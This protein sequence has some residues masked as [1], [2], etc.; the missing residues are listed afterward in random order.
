MDYINR[1][2]GFCDAESPIPGLWRI[3]PQT[4]AQA[5]FPEMHLSSWL[6][7]Q[8]GEVPIYAIEPAGARPV[9]ACYEWLAR[10]IQPDTIILVDGGTDSLMFGDEAGLGTPEGDMVSLLAVNSLPDVG[11]KFLV[12]LGFGLDS[13]HGICHAHFLENVA[14]LIAQDGYLGAWSLTREMDEFMFY[15]DACEHVFARLPRQPS[16]VNTSIIAAVNGSFGNHHMTKRTEGSNLFINPL[17]GFYWSF[18]LE[19][20]VKRNLML[21]HIEHTA[22]ITQVSMAIERFRDNLP[23]TRSWTA[24][25]AEKRC[26]TRFND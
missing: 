15:R 11:R 12:C 18:R 21:G 4:S 17:M 8:F 22:S 3:S 16:I 10:T 7:A 25:P 2:L 23:K 26:H 24:I 19:S 20:V 6:S 1:L 14:S 9:K 13:F 5:Y